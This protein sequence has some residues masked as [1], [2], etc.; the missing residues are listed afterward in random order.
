MIPFFDLGAACREIQVE[1]ESAVL[2]SLRS[3]W[4]FGGLDLGTFE[5]KVAALTEAEYCVDA[6]YSRGRF[7]I[8]ESM[9][10]RLL[11]LLMG[12]QLDDTKIPPVIRAIKEAAHG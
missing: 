8:A 3:G 4:C 5:K 2:A 11:S 7:L 9:A 12:S 1:L 10:H 6:G